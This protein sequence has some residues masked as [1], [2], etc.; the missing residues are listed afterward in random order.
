MVLLYTLLI[1]AFQGAKANPTDIEM[2]NLGKQ[3]INAE[4]HQKK[5]ETNYTITSDAVFFADL[6]E[7]GWTKEHSRYFVQENNRVNKEEMFSMD[8]HGVLFHYGIL[9]H[10]GHEGMCSLGENTYN[11]F[12]GNVFKDFAKDYENNFDEVGHHDMQNSFM[13]EAKTHHAKVMEIVLQ[14]KEKIASAKAIDEQKAAEA[15]RVAHRLAEEKAQEMAKQK[16]EKERLAKQLA[17]AKKLEEASLAKQKADAI[18]KQVADAKQLADAQSKHTAKISNTAPKPPILPSGAR[19]DASTVSVTRKNNTPSPAV[20]VTIPVAPTLPLDTRSNVSASSEQKPASHASSV[21]GYN[22]LSKNVPV[23]AALNGA[24]NVE[25]DQDKP[26]LPPVLA[27]DTR[28]ET[29][30]VAPA[31]IAKPPLAPAQ[32]V[33]AAHTDKVED[34]AHS[35]STDETGAF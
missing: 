21:F 24:F 11:V 34:D 35:V 7:V 4:K 22:R 17:E 3:Q 2:T 1:L 27:L 8:E 14:Q 30:S 29:S 20:I 10:M 6:K 15:K 23:V 9:V 18:A 19:S 28:S 13:D 16:L 31:A 33:V 5:I 25:H 32:A 26:A 12:A